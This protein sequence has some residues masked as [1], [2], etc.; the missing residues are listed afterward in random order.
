MTERT[1][2]TRFNLDF[3]Y[4]LAM[5]QPCSGDHIKQRLLAED[6]DRVPHGTHYSAIGELIEDG[7]VEKRKTDGHENE[8][9]LTDDARDLLAADVEMRERLLNLR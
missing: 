9:W 6:Y 5:E 7:L 8:Y 3:L 2:L 4:A 1:E